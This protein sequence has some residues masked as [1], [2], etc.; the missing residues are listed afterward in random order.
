MV[1]PVYGDMIEEPLISTFSKMSRWL[2]GVAQKNISETEFLVEFPDFYGA[3]LP[4]SIFRC[5]CK[6]AE[7]SSFSLLN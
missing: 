6:V 1:D 4:I 3:N 7:D 2:R 5:A